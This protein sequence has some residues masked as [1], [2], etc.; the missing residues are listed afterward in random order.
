MK[1]WIILFSFLG[2]TGCLTGAGDSATSELLYYGASCE[3]VGGD[4]CLEFYD[5]IQSADAET[6]CINQA[7]NYSPTTQYDLDTTVNLDCSTTGALGRCSTTIGEFVY[8]QGS[9][10]V[11]DAA[12]IADCTA[13]HSGFWESL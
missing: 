9:T 13:T 6:L 12:A 10:W 5:N 4:V 1:L 8:Y 11:N 3:M 7:F 2:L